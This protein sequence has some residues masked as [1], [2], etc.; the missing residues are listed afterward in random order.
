MKKNFPNIAIFDSGRQRR[1]RAWMC[2]ESVTWQDLGQAMGIS[3]NAAVKAL[4]NEHLWPERHACLLSA[5]PTLTAD[6]LPRPELS[7]A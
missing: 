3:S 5:F 7:A 1:L 2:L 6:L 4:S